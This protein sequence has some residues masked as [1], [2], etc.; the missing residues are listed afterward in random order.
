MLCDRPQAMIFSSRFWSIFFSILI[1]T[2]VYLMFVDFAA[3]KMITADAS[4]YLNIGEN[5]THGRGFT[6]SFNLYQHFNTLYHPLWQYMQ[7]VY[8]LLCALVM[9]FKGGIEEVTKVNIFILG[10]NAALVFWIIRQFVPSRLNGLFI[11]F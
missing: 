2:A 10:I 3:I 11:V 7:P 9:F 6:V 8:P 5:I 1:V 4:T